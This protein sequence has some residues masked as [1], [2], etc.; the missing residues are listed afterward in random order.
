MF[1]YVYVC[2]ITN[3]GHDP[4]LTMQLRPELPIHHKNIAQIYSIRGDTESALKHN[5]EAIAL[6]TK[7]GVPVPDT[8][9]TN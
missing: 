7:W 3:N 5:K 1:M 8:K 6:E 4:L 2:S 9:V